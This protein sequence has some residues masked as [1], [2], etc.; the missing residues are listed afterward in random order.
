MKKLIYFLV[1]FSALVIAQELNLSRENL[2]YLEQLPDEIKE[3]VFDQLESRVE[4]TKALD[5]DNNLLK[6]QNSLIEKSILE[7]KLETKKFGYDFFNKIPLTNAP[8]KDIPIANNYKVAINDVLNVN[9]IGSVNSSGEKQVQ[10]DGTIFIDEIGSFYVQGL[11]PDEIE[12]SIRKKSEEIFPNTEVIVSLQELTPIQVYLVG[13]FESPGAYL[14]N[15]LTTI[16]NALINSGGIK[17]TGTLRDIVIKRNA[18]DEISFD[19][20]DLL[21]FGDRSEDLILKSGDTIVV[22]AAGRFIEITGG[23]NRELLY[24]FSAEDSFQDLIKFGLGLS[25]DADSES[26][27][28]SYS[29]NNQLIEENYALNQVSPSKIR[30]IFIPENNFAEQKRI[31]VSGPVL[32]TSSL[33]FGDTLGNYLSDIEFKED[34]YTYY[35]VLVDNQ[36]PDGNKYIAFNAMDKLNDTKVGAN[37]ELLFFSIEDIETIM[38]FPKYLKDKAKIEEK[39]IKSEEQAQRVESQYSALNNQEQ[40]LQQESFKLSNY[41]VNKFYEEY[42]VFN[43]QLLKLLEDEPELYQFISSDQIEFTGAINK[44]FVTPAI[45]EVNIFKIISMLSGLKANADLENIFFADP[46]NNLDIQNYIVGSGEI[47]LAQGNGKNVFIPERNNSSV[48]V[49]I[50]GEVQIP[51]TYTLPAG[52]VLRDVYQQAGGFTKFSSPEAI[53]LTREDIFKSENQAI[54]KARNTLTNSIVNNLVN[55]S[56]VENSL[57]KEIID[58]LIQSSTTTPT[59]RLVGDL[60]AEGINSLRINL[61]DGDKI[62]VPGKLSTVNILGE[63]KQTLTTLYDPGLTISDYLGVAGGFTE[64]SNKRDIY[65]IRSNGTTVSASLGLFGS[66]SPRIKPGD[67]IVVPK[68]LL[69]ARGLA[70]VS[71]ASR[72]ISDVAFSAASLN[73]L[74]N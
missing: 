59:G 27:L 36:N 37:S 66:A 47:S 26:I 70:L 38:V 4:L 25:P 33:V 61:K 45:G 46:L 52:S 12:S 34:I 31:K 60:S 50:D 69:Q 13:E 74:R 20:Y 68:K 53:I 72:V 11:T 55:P 67:S 73:T 17:E 21:I 63:V 49:Y 57:T 10:L 8:L 19:L 51:G 48:T 40:L 35:A 43:V 16:S 64:F 32:N 28:V 3:Q 2:A 14:F 30:K 62:F 23:I 44:E 15:P 5:S 22:G 6:A 56:T 1:I 39:I 65:I 41:E 71:T 9:F 18:G 7:S 24:E 42:S 54:E 58:L 29:K